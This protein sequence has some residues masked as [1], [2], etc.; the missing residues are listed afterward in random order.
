MSEPTTKELIQAT[1]DMMALIE[2]TEEFADCL[3]WTGS[4]SNGNPT[5]TPYGVGQVCTYV[6]RSIYQL[7]TGN[8]KPGVPLDMTCNE[9]LCI[10]PAHMQ[11]TTHA[12][13]GQKAAAR[14]QWK[15]KTRAA[16]IATAKRAGHQSKLTTEIAREIRC[17]SEPG[18]VL[19]ERYGVCRAVINGIKAGTRWKDYSNPF[20]GLMG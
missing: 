5:Y 10:N 8:L 12:K 19:A 20:A 3:L 18:P 4:T 1:L 6:R 13:I 16:R 11:P 2:R 14:G 17:S 7:A 15:T 9:R